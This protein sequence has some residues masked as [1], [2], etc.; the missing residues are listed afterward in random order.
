MDRRRFLKL[1]V[2]AAASAAL[3]VTMLET[4]PSG[5]TWHNGATS[6]WASKSP[7][8]ILAD[9]NAALEAAYQ[10]YDGALTL[11]LSQYNLIR[12]LETLDPPVHTPLRSFV[13]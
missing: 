7:S 2:S 1:A 10:P 3:P 11:T 6:S 5:A 4:L 12:K 13:L 8:E 9:V